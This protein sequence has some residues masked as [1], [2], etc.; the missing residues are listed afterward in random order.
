MLQNQYCLPHTP[1]HQWG[2]GSIKCPRSP[3][4]LRA[5]ESMRFIVKS[6]ER[7]AEVKWMDSGL[8]GCGWVQW[9]IAEDCGRHRRRILAEH[10]RAWARAR[11]RAKYTQ[12][13][14]STCINVL[15][16]HTQIQIATCIY[17][18]SSA[19][20]DIHNHNHQGLFI[21]SYN[22]ERISF[23]LS[24]HLHIVV[25]ETHDYL[26]I[27]LLV[28]SRKQMASG[29]D[30]KMLCPKLEQQRQS[31]E[32]KKP[33]LVKAVWPFFSVPLEMK[34]LFRQCCRI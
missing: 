6:R 20:L 29:S 32:E 3:S 18:K 8:S 10:K 7:A 34:S 24:Q 30:L 11:A 15:H 5:E 26:A 9:I 1:S 33:L 23:I 21:Y 17:H 31:R 14:Q 28:A 22:L 27:T 4:P 16:E 13:H 25:M 2:R 12:V 19:K